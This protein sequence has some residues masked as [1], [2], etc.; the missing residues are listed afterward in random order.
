MK[1][2][3]NDKQTAKINLSSLYGRFI[4]E[5]EQKY[6]VN[7]IHGVNEATEIVSEVCHAFNFIYADTD[8]VILKDS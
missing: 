2:M 1:N 4:T 8:S 7:D 5:D 3:C 6:I